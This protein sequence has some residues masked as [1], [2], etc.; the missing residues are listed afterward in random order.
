MRLIAFLAFVFVMAGMMAAWKSVADHFTRAEM[1][2]FGL[3]FISGNTLYQVAHRLRY[4]HWF[5]PPNDPP[6]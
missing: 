4:G 2:A 3:G 5:D 1:V 6:R